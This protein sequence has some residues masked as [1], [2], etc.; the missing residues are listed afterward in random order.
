MRPVK[1]SAEGAVSEDAI[2]NEDPLKKVVKWLNTQGYPL[3]MRVA[4]AFQ[5]AGFKVFQSA[6]YA[7]PETQESREIDV[8]AY[9]IVFLRSRAPRERGKRRPR[10]RRVVLMWAVE[11]KSTPAPWIAM[12]PTEDGM[13]EPPTAFMFDLPCTTWFENAVDECVDTDI[14]EMLACPREK[15][16]YGMATLKDKE[17]DTAFEAMLSAAKASVADY[18]PHPAP[19]L[20]LSQPVAVTGGKLFACQ[21]RSGELH[22]EEIDDCMVG[23]SYRIGTRAS[24]VNVVT[25]RGLESFVQ[26]AAATATSIAAALEA[27]ADAIL[28]AL[29][30]NEREWRAQ[31]TACDVE[32]EIPPAPG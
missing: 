1:I 27:E 3:E 2:K 31:R 21:L 25:A 6:P 24:V 12:R 19:A 28:D 16:A 20:I 11:C 10:P 4:A 30:V 14:R 9:R 23:L 17:K 18:G 7:D 29:D 13:E 5:R 15:Y 8:R 32:D 26:R 22:V